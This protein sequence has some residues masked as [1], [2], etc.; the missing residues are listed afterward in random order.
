MRTRELILSVMVAAFLSVGGSFLLRGVGAQT[1][2]SGPVPCTTDTQC[3]SG[4]SCTAGRCN[5]PSPIWNISTAALPQN[6]SF[7]VTGSG[8][9][10]GTLTVGS[11]S[12]ASGKAAIDA[13]GNITTKGCLGAIY[14][15]PSA[16]ASNGNAGGYI[17]ANAKCPTDMHVCTTSEMITSINCGEILKTGKDTNGGVPMWISTFAPS[18]PTPTNDC[19][20]WKTS[21]SASVGVV[22]RFDA[23]GGNAGTAGCNSALKFACC[24]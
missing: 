23:Q 4:W 22:Y 3:P 2:G 14:Q 24:K 12:A 13:A 11:M 5:L 18:L 6:A 16:T 17:G 10:G 21:S 8:N 19:G 7:N 20:G 1:S 15:Q 9:V